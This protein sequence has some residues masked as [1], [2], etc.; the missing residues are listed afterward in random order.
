[1]AR[2]QAFALVLAVGCVGRNQP[3]AFDASSPRANPRT[4]TVIF[5]DGHVYVERGVAYGAPPPGTVI[6]VTDP[7]VGPMQAPTPSGAIKT[8]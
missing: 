7:E 8:K 4:P 3:S 5:V 1:M 6:P 2:L